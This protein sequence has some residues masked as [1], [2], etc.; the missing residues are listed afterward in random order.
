MYNRW[1]RW[2]DMD[3]FARIMMGLAEQAPDNKTISIPSH[4]NCVSTA[5]QRIEDMTLNGSEKAL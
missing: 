3:V 4:R 5:G 1:K 2:S